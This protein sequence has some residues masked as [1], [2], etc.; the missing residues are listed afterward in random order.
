MNTFFHRKSERKQKLP[1]SFLIKNVAYSVHREDSFFV[2]HS[3][4]YH[5]RLMKAGR[6]SSKQRNYL[7]STCFRFIFYIFI[8]I[9]VFREKKKRKKII[10]KNSRSFGI[11]Y[12]PTF[13]IA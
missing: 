10:R 7:R 5:E 4:Y 1:K 8:F 11:V 2:F 6:K 13:A 9:V 3:K 12:P